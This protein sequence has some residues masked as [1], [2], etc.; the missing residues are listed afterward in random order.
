MIELF[1]SKNNFPVC[2]SDIIYYIPEDRYTSFMANRVAI[3]KQIIMQLSDYAVKINNFAII[4][5]DDNGDS[6]YEV[7]I[8]LL[9]SKSRPCTSNE[10][11]T[12]HKSNLDILSQNWY[13][14]GLDK[15]NEEIRSK[16][17]E[18]LPLEQSIKEKRD[19]IFRKIFE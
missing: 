17:I 8:D 14:F 13:K 3:S 11:K 6:V 19:A 4:G 18:L 10:I 5:K 9:K 7:S 16:P 1:R 2:A 12:W 15:I